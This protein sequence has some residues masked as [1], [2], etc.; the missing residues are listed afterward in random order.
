MATQDRASP[1]V[2]GPASFGLDIG[3]FSDFLYS[4]LLLSAILGP[5]AIFLIF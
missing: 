5:Q 4:D 1:S 2:V 3:I